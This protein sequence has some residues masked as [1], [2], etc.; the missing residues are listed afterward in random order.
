M[1]KY[2]D[3]IVFH[4]HGLLHL[5]FFP[6]LFSLYSEHKVDKVTHYIEIAVT[7]LCQNIQNYF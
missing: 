2:L 6:A 1:G 5:T 3:I 7:H 4:K